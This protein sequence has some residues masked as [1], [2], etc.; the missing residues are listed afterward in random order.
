MPSSTLGDP[1]TRHIADSGESLQAYPNIR[2]AAQMLGVSASTLSRRADRTAERRGERDRVLPPAEVLRLAS[3]FRRRSVN[4]I[5]QALLDHARATAPDE[6]TRVEEDIEGFF[7]AHTVAEQREE[8]PPAR[9]PD[10]AA[11]DVRADRFPAR[12]GR[13]RTAGHHPGLRS[14]A[15]S[16]TRQRLLAQVEAAR[17][18]ALHLRRLPETELAR[19]RLVVARRQIEVDV[20]A[21]ADL[22]RDRVDV[23]LQDEGAGERTKA[24]VRIA[25]D[26]GAKSDRRDE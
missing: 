3:V 23:L 24:Q 16:L 11:F 19:V 20:A 15:G 12:P 26:V 13:R 6:V 10:V 17:P 4:D 1:I 14:A 22:L 21:A 25:R 8:A 9:P 2:A 5:A 7:E 18:K